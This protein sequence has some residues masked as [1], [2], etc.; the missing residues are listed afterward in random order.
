MESTAAIFRQSAGYVC[1]CFGKTEVCQSFSFQELPQLVTSCDVSLQT[2][3]IPLK[4]PSEE[5]VFLNKSMQTETQVDTEQIISG[6][7]IEID[8]QS[9]TESGHEITT[10]NANRRSLISAIEQSSSEVNSLTLENEKLKQELDEKCAEVDTLKRNLAHISDDL[11]NKENDLVSFEDVKKEHELK[12]SQ[13]DSSLQRL[14][15]E[16]IDLAEQLKERSEEME[17]LDEAKET[18]NRR[19]LEKEAE[20]DALKDENSKLVLLSEQS[21]VNSAE[22]EIERTTLETKISEMNLENEKLKTEVNNLKSQVSNSGEVSVRFQAKVFELEHEIELLKSE[23]ANVAD[24]LSLKVEN[25]SHNSNS[26]EL[27]DLKQIVENMTLDVESRDELIQLLKAEIEEKEQ[28]WKNQ[29]S[30]LQAQ[31]DKDPRAIEKLEPVGE[32]DFSSTDLE[33]ELV[34]AKQEIERLIVDNGILTE[35]CGAAN[36][37]KYE[38]ESRLEQVLK[39]FD[40]KTNEFQDRLDDKQVENEKLSGS[41]RKIEA[42]RSELEAQ[43]SEIEAQKS[44]IEAQKSEIEA[45]KSEI[46]AQKSELEA[47][48]FEKSVENCDEMEG[49][50]SNFEVDLKL[51]TQS[52]ESKTEEI[53]NLEQLV[54]NLN[55]E[56]CDKEQNVHLDLETKFVAEKENLESV[57]AALETS[58]TEM[59]QRISNFQDQ[60]AELSILRE[61]NVTL[62][63]K[64]ANLV[65]EEL[66]RERDF[67]DKSL[68]FEDEVLSVETSDSTCQTEDIEIVDPHEKERQFDEIKQKYEEQLQN[69]RINHSREKVELEEAILFIEKKSYANEREVS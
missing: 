56:L 40:L 12:I 30:E 21:D 32:G 64:I 54:E 9:S 35:K 29:L 69:C 18:I 27:E 17:K 26:D 7:P 34:S 15:D 43:K 19:I 28:T 53:A 55:L 23:K 3:E 47:Q 33:K 66:K 61:E 51:M 59:T 2:E 48:K 65:S 22:N 63:D 20:I 1:I 39:D 41:L 5:A 45:Q 11:Q 38:L 10:K 49:C 67:A 16:K 24:Q 46:E 62:Q 58:K 6:E 60:I 13:L 68:Q 52:L 31:L 42:E 8:T 14:T 25:P 57:I 44:E 4:F 36:S 50:S 37:V